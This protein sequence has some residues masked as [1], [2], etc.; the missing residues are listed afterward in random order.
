MWE[1]FQIMPP[2]GRESGSFLSKSTG[3]GRRNLQ[4][5]VL[6]QMPWGSSGLPP[7]MAADKCIKQEKH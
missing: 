6:V 5:N 3:P 2:R 7:G 4:L 1:S